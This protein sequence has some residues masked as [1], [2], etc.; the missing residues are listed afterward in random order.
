VS[1]VNRL[2]NRI[3]AIIIQYKW[4]LIILFAVIF[5]HQLSTVC[6]EIVFIGPKKGR[7]FKNPEG[8]NFQFLRISIGTELV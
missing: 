7:I 5:I 8:L 2:F 1:D 6:I 4:V 3:I